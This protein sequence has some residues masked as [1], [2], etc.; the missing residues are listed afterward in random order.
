[1]EL[2][3]RQKKILQAIVEEYI[4]TAEPVGSKSIAQNAELNVSSATIRNEMAALESL[5]YLEQ[6]HTSAGRVPSP[7]GYRLYVDEL[8]NR[9]QELSNDET[10]RMD[11]VM[12]SKMDELDHMLNNAGKLI[13]QITKYPTY[14]MAVVPSSTSIRRFELMSADEGSFAAVLMT[15]AKQIKNKVIR[16]PASATDEQFHSVAQTLNEHFSGAP[17]SDYTAQAIGNAVSQCGA[18]GSVASLTLHFAM[19]VLEGSEHR[20]ISVQGTS[21]LLQHPEFRDMD[22]AQKMLTYLS[23]EQKL[24]K[25]SNPD[26]NS[27]VKFM[28]GPENLAEELKD[29][30]VVVASYDI[31]DDMQGIIGVVGPTRMDYAKVA[32]RLSYF[33]ENLGK[34]ISG[35]KP[36]LALGDGGEKDN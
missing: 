13:S 27:R 16:F 35:E 28:I 10:S 9:Q 2:S 3:E 23:E 12:R 5:G 34:I 22:K 25:I 6:P 15:S 17:L 4:R 24:M 18:L 14:T 8:M 32:A 20:E 7:K 36:P 26:S 1:M 11:S 21:T 33:A 31:G 30:S 19:E 29:A